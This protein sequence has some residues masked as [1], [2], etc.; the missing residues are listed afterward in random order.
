MP[1]RVKRDSDRFDFAA[2]EFQAAHKKIA[3]VALRALV[4]AFADDLT[5]LPERIASSSF[6][7]RTLAPV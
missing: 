6:L 3:P 1:R 2:G 7:P 5:E 4:G